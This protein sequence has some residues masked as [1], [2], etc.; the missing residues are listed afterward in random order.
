MGYFKFIKIQFFKVEKSNKITIES[1]DD[2]TNVLKIDGV[3]D[4]DCGEYRCEAVNEY[5]SAWT[6]G[7]IDFAQK[8]GEGEAPDFLEPVKPITVKTVQTF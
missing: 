6:E 7:P 3:T 5:G 4:E 8:T 2:G 1:Y